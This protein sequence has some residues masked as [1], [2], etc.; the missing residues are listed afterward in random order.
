MYVNFTSVNTH[1]LTNVY[2]HNSRGQKFYHQ[3]AAKS[4]FLLEA[5]ENNSYLLLPASRVTA[6]LTCGLFLTMTSL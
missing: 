5:L 4:A 3:K 2:S 1:A 6:L